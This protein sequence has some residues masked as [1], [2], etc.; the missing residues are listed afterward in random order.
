MQK[1][2][3]TQLLGVLTESINKVEKQ[4][5]MVAQGLGKTQ[6]V[7]HAGLKDVDKFV[8]SLLYLIIF[9]S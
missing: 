9:F 7:V 6:H 1:K 5:R 4:R 8:L 3:E 2:V